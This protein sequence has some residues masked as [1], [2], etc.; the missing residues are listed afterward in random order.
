MV[1]IR[2]VQ[3]LPAKLVANTLN[4]N[5]NKYRFVKK[6]LLMSGAFMIIGVKLIPPHDYGS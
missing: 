1:D 6:E 5:L 4:V 3:C 2:Q